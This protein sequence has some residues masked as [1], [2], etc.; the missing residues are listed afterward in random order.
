MMSGV[1]LS[2][3]RKSLEYPGELTA[4]QGYHHLDIS[5]SF[6]EGQTP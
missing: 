2:V 1:D 5:T 3:I 6:S 4:G